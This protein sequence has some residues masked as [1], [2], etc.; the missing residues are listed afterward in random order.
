MYPY[1]Y[2][3]EFDED[4]Y[5]IESNEFDDP[6]HFNNYM[7]NTSGIKLIPLG[8]C[9]PQPHIDDIE[10][11]LNSLNSYTDTFYYP[12]YEQHDDTSSSDE[13]SDE[14]IKEQ[15]DDDIKKDHVTYNDY[16]NEPKDRIEKS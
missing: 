10:K 13:S 11:D 9:L 1:R 3:D 2:E 7:N 4:G 14:C 12:G 8:S 5:L 6:D 16:N 15:H